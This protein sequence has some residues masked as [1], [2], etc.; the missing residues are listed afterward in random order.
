MSPG[1]SLSHWNKSCPPL[2][3]LVTGLLL[4]AGLA[5]TP[6]P[7]AGQP[8]PA[9]AEAAVLAQLPER[10]SRAADA[11][12]AARP[13][14]GGVTYLVLHLEFRTPGA[15]DAFAAAV[16]GTACHVFARDQE[17]AD[18][19]VRRGD[20]KG[21]RLLAEKAR[22]LAGWD[23]AGVGRVPPP[24]P[25]PTPLPGKGK[26]SEPVVRGGA[27]GLTGKGVI[28]AVIDSGL[29]F[30]H[31]DFLTAGGDGKPASRL[32]FFWDT[33]RAHDPAAGGR[34]A[35]VRFPDGQPAGTIFSRDE[36]T[37]D[38]RG[39]ANKLGPGDEQGHGTACAG[40][41][42]GRGEAGRAAG[43]AHDYTGVAPQAHLIAVRIGRER[44]MPNA[45]LLPAVCE[46][47][48]GVARAE[49]LPLVVSCSFG[50]HLGLPDGNR[51]DERHLSKRFLRRPGRLLC[52]AAGN[53]A[54]QGIHTAVTFK[55]G[56]SARLDWEVSRPTRLQVFVPGARPGD[57]KA[58]GLGGTAVGPEK[59]EWKSLGGYLVL[60]FA[61]PKGKGALRL[62]TGRDTELR[63]DAYLPEWRDKNTYRFLRGA[64]NAN[65]IC[66]PAA[67]LGGITVG[68]YDFDDQFHYRGKQ[69][70]LPNLRTGKGLDLGRLCDFSCAG[71]LAPAQDGAVKPDVVAPGRYF[72]APAAATAG[73][74]RDTTGK[75]RLF[76]GTSAATPYA[77]GVLALLLEKKPT[78]TTEEL[79]GLLRKCATTDAQ[80]GRCPNPDWGAGK[81][82]RAAVL[83]LIDAVAAR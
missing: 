18:V 35:P 30:R 76:D 6:L 24:A 5:H 65:L 12:E 77:A 74:V 58:E 64:S 39:G 80:T 46:W 23:A 37:A 16:K 34:P 61:V 3:A 83:R 69:L 7:G 32:L 17:F 10:L 25:P 78:L 45:Y 13:E 52:A 60:R 50:G 22:D 81:L 56:E 53:E 27:G 71:Y 55:A 73:G 26:G 67:A 1:K 40:I 70:S 14:A 38:V 62:S 29:D 2:A 82:D 68:A 31:P 54:Y 48:D 21:L 57:V 33:T 79:R 63:A 72:T 28:V 49:G 47:L 36:L 4:I 19:M 42:A 11:P 9:P 43:A 51:V 59:P 8:P 75:Y 20:E 44:G 41:A 15:C 66:S